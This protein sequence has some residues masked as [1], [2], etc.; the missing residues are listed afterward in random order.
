MAVEI[1]VVMTLYREG[2]F[3][4][5][6]IDS[7]LEQSFR[8]FEIVLVDNNAD[9]ATMQVARRYQNK[10]PDIIRIVKEPT[11]GTSS[12]RNRGIWEATGQYIAM[13]DGDDLMRPNRLEKQVEAARAHP[14]AALISSSYEAFVVE[15][16]QKVFFSKQRDIH[17]DWVDLLFKSQK[18]SFLRDFYIPL[19]ST[20]FFN[21][22]K[23]IEFGGFDTFFDKVPG[24]DIDFGIRLWKKEKYFHVD[25]I[26]VNYRAKSKD[27]KNLLSKSWIQRLKR[28]DRIIRNLHD[29]YDDYPGNPLKEPLR[30]L[31][32]IW[33]R[34]ASLHYFS[35]QDGKKYGRELLRR[36]LSLNMTSLDTWKITIKSYFPKNTYQKLFWFKEWESLPEHVDHEAYLRNLYAYPNQRRSISNQKE[37]RRIAIFYPLSDF[38]NP[39][40]GA[41]VRVNNMVRF[42]SNEVDE[43]RV[44]QRWNKQELLNG[45]IKLESVR[46]NED[47]FLPRAF[48]RIFSLVFYKI[49]ARNQKEE[50]TFLLRF[51]EP[52]F[53]KKFEKSVYELVDWADAVIIEL[54]FWGQIV[55]K[56]CKRK[57]IPFI[58][59]THDFVTDHIHSNK[60]VR[61]FVRLMELSSLKKANRVIA[62]TN[63]DARK[64]E[65]Y[66]IKADVIENKVDCLYWGKKFPVNPI[67]YLENNGINLPKGP[68][69]LFVGGGHYPNVD[70]VEDIKKMAASLLGKSEVTFIIVGNCARPEIRSNWIALGKVEQDVILALYTVVDL[71]LVPLRNGSGSS[72]KT[73]E[74]MAAGCALLGTNIGFR[75][76]DIVKNHHAFIDDDLGKYPQLILNLLSDPKRRYE[77]GNNA[78]IWSSDSDYRKEFIKYLEILNIPREKNIICNGYVTNP[79]CDPPD[80][81]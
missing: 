81:V 19:P 53:Y 3:L 15:N 22:N 47:T 28:Q 14:E 55:A 25:D 35:C 13:S 26:L 16:G 43:V 67:G 44:M 24:E 65:K 6:A 59:T 39:S 42:I 49:L 5:E 62:V 56:A 1:S 33:L 68:L 29:L 12:A 77:L 63:N 52:F 76:L 50:A 34:E 58:L 69:C 41:S 57:K 66:G 2:A 40:S 17:L 38:H 7:V 74:A 37:I 72:I 11:Q 78:R 27:L 51:V 31:T 73:I 9:E 10:F 30:I 80:R 54:P 60:L 21:R 48:E 4:E 23:I 64:F 75:G 46:L 18:D 71:V 36:S 79:C 45:K 70:A 8:D 20:I 32:S 61:F